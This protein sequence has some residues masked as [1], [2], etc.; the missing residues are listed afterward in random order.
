MAPRRFTPVHD[1]GTKLRLTV[2]NLFKQVP[3]PGEIVTVSLSR[4]AVLAG[5]LAAVLALGACGAAPTAQTGNSA[6]TATSVKD[7]GGL[8]ALVAA[9]KKEGTLNAIAL[10]RDWANYGAVI[11]GFTAKYGIK[12]Q[13]ENPGGSSQDEI[14]AGSSRKGQDRAHQVLDL[15]SD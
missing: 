13:D 12:V 11:D 2:S 10:P 5:G 9:A 3:T 1:P 8:D 7:L 4:T 14:T 6:A 15:A